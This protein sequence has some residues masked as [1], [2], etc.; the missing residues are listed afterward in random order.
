MLHSKACMRMRI[1]FKQHDGGKQKLARKEPTTCLP[2]GVWV[3]ELICQSV[4]RDSRCGMVVLVFVFVLLVSTTILPDRS[5][6]SC[7]L[8]PLFL[9]IKVQYRSAY[10]MDQHLQPFWEKLEPLLRDGHACYLPLAVEISVSFP[11]LHK[12]AHA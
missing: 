9:Y 8:Q 10:A 2:R 3:K 12:P 11:F 7:Y 1:L 4:N 5:N 6:S